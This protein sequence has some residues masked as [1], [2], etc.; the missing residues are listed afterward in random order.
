MPVITLSLPAALGFLALFLTIGAVLIFFTLRGQGNAIAAQQLTPSKTPT[1]T[2]TATLT[3]TETNTPLPLPTFTPLPPVSYQVAS[4]DTCT[5]IAANFHVSVDSIVQL[6]NL[7]IACNTLK[8]GQ[9]LTIPQPTPTASPQPTATLSGAEATTSACEKQDYTVKDGDTL[10]SI[11]K[12]SGVPM[13][14]IKSYNGLVGDVVFSGTKLVIP[15]CLRNTSPNSATQT[16]TT[17]PP[18]PAPILL[19]PVNGAAFSAADIISLQWAAVGALG[20]NEAYAIT[21]EDMTAQADS[22]KP[23]QIVEYVTDTKL[24]I[25]ASF[26]PADAKPHILNWSVLP[27][28]QVGTTQDGSPIWQPSGAVSEKRGLIWTGGG[29]APQA[30]TSTP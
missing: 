15:L 11:S 13:D 27:V 26:R 4:G 8:A 24:I 21:V 16:P 25:P 9:A 7:P 3:P 28:R 12:S 29:T 18:Y 1:I 23:R 20:Q 14:A 2:T 10:G 6:N 17:P 30:A 19:L 5:S 22:G